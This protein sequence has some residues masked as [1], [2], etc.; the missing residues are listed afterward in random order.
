MALGDILEAIHADS[1]EI[2]SR[3]I[4]EARAEADRTLHSAREEA[5]AEE[6]RLAASLDDRIRAEQSRIMSR[7]HLEA[8]R[9]RRAVRENLYRAALDGVRQ[10]IETLRRTPDYRDLLAILIVEAVAVLP[11]ATTVMCDPVDIDVVE[12]IAEDRGFDVRVEAR[13]CP[14]GGVVVWAEGRS[15]DNTLASRLRRA[16]EHLRF[17]AGELIP[18]LR[19][20]EG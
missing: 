15:V 6:Q 10:R 2:A 13:E 9:E 7:A 5:A 12:A 19:G 17:L 1:R 14:L 20:D 8:S 3:V 18:A 4:S 11:E 16:D